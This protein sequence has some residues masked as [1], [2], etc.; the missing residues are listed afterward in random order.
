MYCVCSDREGN[1][2]IMT[3]SER[4]QMLSVL[5]DLQQE[6]PTHVVKRCD[7]EAEAQDYVKGINQA[8]D[9]LNRL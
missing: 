2:S 6:I 4:E 8:N 1:L 5:M 3:A 7:T 9:L